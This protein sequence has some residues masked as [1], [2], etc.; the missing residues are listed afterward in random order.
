VAAS[1]LGFSLRRLFAVQ[2][3]PRFLL[4]SRTEKQRFAFFKCFENCPA[5]NQFARSATIKLHVKK[6]FSRPQNLFSV[7]SLFLD[8]IYVS[9]FTSDKLTINKHAPGKLG[10]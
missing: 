6:S 2:S 8:A 1:A 3:Q 10:D 9:V 5:A 4:N 7:N